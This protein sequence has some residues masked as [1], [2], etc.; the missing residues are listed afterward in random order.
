MGV[1]FVEPGLLFLDFSSDC[2]IRLRDGC[3]LFLASL[4]RLVLSMQGFLLGF[5]NFLRVYR[6]ASCLHRGPTVVL[7]CRHRTTNILHRGRALQLRRWA[8]ALGL[9]LIFLVIVVFGL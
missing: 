6:A 4:G 8:A 9:T 2:I 3:L 1:R 7:H 5:T